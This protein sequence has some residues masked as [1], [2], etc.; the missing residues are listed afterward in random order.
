MIHS[1]VNRPMTEPGCHSGMLLGMEL[2]CNYTQPWLRFT[3]GITHTLHASVLDPEFL[4][5][6]KAKE[7]RVVIPGGVH[8]GQIMGSKVSKQCINV[9]F[10]GVLFNWYCYNTH[11]DNA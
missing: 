1:F 4:A 7:R 3:A 8:T 2:E 5:R 6:H 9:T 11:H 10:Y